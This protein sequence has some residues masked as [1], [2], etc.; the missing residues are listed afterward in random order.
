MT[1]VAGL[2][3][4]TIS[5]DP[6]PISIIESIILSPRAVGKVMAGLLGISKK[7]EDTSAGR[8]FFFPSKVI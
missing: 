3:S 6:T 1:D 4:T 5:L 8:S 2:T 7:M